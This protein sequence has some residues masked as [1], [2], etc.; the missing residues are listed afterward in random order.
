MLVINVKENDSLEKALKKFKKKN[1]G[2]KRVL[3]DQ[4]VLSGMGNIYAD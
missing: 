3:L 4:G 2:I 1:S